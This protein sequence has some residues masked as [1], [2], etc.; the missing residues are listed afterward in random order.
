M[1]IH[2]NSYDLASDDS[3]WPLAI[4][5][6]G[7]GISFQTPQPETAWQKAGG[8]EQSNYPRGRDWRHIRIPGVVDLMARSNGKK[9]MSQVEPSRAP[10]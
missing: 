1:S 3:W 2:L 6:G 7:C 9:R 5:G 4:V 8:R 10:S